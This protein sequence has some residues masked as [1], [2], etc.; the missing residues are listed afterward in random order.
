MARVYLLG[1]VLPGKELSIRDT[2]RGIKGVVQADVITGHYDIAVIIEANSTAE[3]FDK[4]LKNIRKIK[5][6]TRT[7]TFLAVE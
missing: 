3:I 2:C 4:I 7:E 5:G 6:L 1:N